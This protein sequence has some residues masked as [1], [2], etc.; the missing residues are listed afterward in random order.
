MH[1]D[2]SEVGEVNQELTWLSSLRCL[3]HED[4]PE[5]EFGES[6]VTRSHT[7][8]ANH[9]RSIQDILLA[10]LHQALVLALIGLAQLAL[11][12]AELDELLQ[13]GMRVGIGDLLMER[14]EGDARVE[15]FS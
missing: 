6:R 10:R 8:R 14:Q 12:V 9:V 7:R 4:G 5:L 3:V 2:V 11:V 15:R 13:L 1:S